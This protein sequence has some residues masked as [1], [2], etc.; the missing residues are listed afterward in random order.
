MPVVDASARTSARNLSAVL[1]IAFTWGPALDLIVE[2][3]HARQGA[4]GWASRL[5]MAVVALAGRY[6]IARFAFGSGSFGRAFVRLPMGVF[7]LGTALR[8]VDLAPLFTTATQAGR[9]AAIFQNVVFVPLVVALYAAALPL[10]LR[11]PEKGGAADLGETLLMA[12][13]WAALPEVALSYFGFWEAGWKSSL[14]GLEWKLRLL[15]GVALPLAAAVGVAVGSARVRTRHTWRSAF[16]AWVVLPAV[17][18][19]LLSGLASLPLPLVPHPLVVASARARDGTRLVIV[20]IQDDPYDVYLNVRRP[21]GVW[22][23]YRLAYGD[24]LWVGRIDL[25]AEESVASI[26]SYGIEVALLDWEGEKLDKRVALTGFVAIPRV[27]ESPFDEH[28]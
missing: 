1:G 17:G 21:D 10:M 13:L 5:A 22:M 12:S 15:L 2:V 7:V 3:M 6:G 18:L 23:R 20:E 16:A 14:L 24:P 25:K 11:R 28:Y 27:I 4:A 26:S 19:A 9:G 8:A